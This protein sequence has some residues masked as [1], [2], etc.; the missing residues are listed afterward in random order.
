MKTKS[1]FDFSALNF[2]RVAVIGC[3]GSGKTTFAR[4]L[5]EILS[6]EVIHLDR[7]LWNSGWQM[8]PYDERAVIHDNLIAREEWII[9]GMWKSHLPSRFEKAT[10]VIFLDYPRRISFSRALKRRIKYSGKQRDDIADGCTEKLDGYF[11][12]Y[13]W[14]FNKKVRPLILELKENNPLI[15]VETMRRPKE[16]ETF[17]KELEQY[18]AESKRGVCN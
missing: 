17:L 5:G 4:R 7:V 16:T 11:V 14:T 8:L 15:T 9:D 2:S 1:Q 13:I 12:K 10:C 18:I 6:R 3:P